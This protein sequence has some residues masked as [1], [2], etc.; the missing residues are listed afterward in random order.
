MENMKLQLRYCALGAVL[1]LSGCVTG[2]RNI[3]LNPPEYENV[4][5]SEGLVY[6]GTI[7]DKRRFEAKP[8]DPSTPSVKGDLASSSQ[9]K[10]STL[11]GRQRNSYG[12]A[13][14]DL[15]LPKGGTV[16]EEIRDL[17]IRGLESRGYTIVDDE[18]APIKLAVQ[19]DKFWA[20]FSPGMWSISFEA[21][22]QC[23]VIFSEA[24]GSR[25]FDITG[26]GINKGQVASNENWELTYQRAFS[27]FLKNLDKILD[28]EGL[29]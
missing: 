13:M 23:K 20:W 7:D 24:S 12:A 10:L 17:L 26:Y 25:V 5:S 9:E 2:T 21:D 27:D 4:K 11:I 3:D 6:I 1:L 14:G 16:Q 15:A 18:N 28:K 29:Y 22:I 8:R 19:I